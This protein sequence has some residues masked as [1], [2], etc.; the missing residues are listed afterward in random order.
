MNIGHYISIGGIGVAAGVALWIA[1]L[2]RKQMRQNELFRVNQELGVMPPPSPV[3]VF[4]KRHY[5]TGAIIWTVFW[6][7]RD[8]F[9]NKPFDRTT[10]FFMGLN[11][12][13][14]TLL[15]VF[16]AIAQLWD[17]ILQIHQLL[18]KH[19]VLLERQ[20]ETS[21]SLTRT[22]AVLLQLYE[23]WCDASK[24]PTLLKAPDTPKQPE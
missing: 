5:T 24:S 7:C 3:W 2:Q 4:V 6:L 11:F 17:S 1:Y 10:I 18:N 21:A 23:T 19:V 22:D 16:R 8:G 20:T 9:S 15:I 14:L 12:T 13:S